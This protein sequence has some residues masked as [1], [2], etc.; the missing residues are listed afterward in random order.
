[1]GRDVSHSVSNHL[2]RLVT[3]II[4][5]AAMTQVKVQCGP[6]HLV[7]LMTTEAT[8]GLKL[9]PGSVAVAI[10]KS[11]QVIIQTRDDTTQGHG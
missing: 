9:V 3:N 4:A 2:V 11:I 1:M 6:H 7:S 5:D 10:V 8:R